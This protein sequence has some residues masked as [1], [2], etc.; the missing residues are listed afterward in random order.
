MNEDRLIEIETALA[1]HEQ[2]II[3]MSDLITQQWKMIEALKQQLDRAHSK[4]E[5]MQADKGEEGDALSG[6]EFARQN[7]PP[8]Y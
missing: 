8:H 2:Q 7:T 3:E 4:I 5:Q 1:H 6:I